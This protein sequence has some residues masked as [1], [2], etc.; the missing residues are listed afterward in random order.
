MVGVD[1][2]VTAARQ[3]SDDG[4]LVLI[5]ADLEG[6]ARWPLGDQ[7]F[8]GV[9][10]TNYL[11]RPL[12]PAIVGAV[13]PAGVLIYE[14]FGTGN[15]RLGRPRNSEFLLRPG[16]LLDAA[17]PVLTIVAYENVVLA[18]P[19]RVV[20]RIAAVGRQHPLAQAMAPPA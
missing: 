18:D 16:E 7:R 9:I 5:E 15:E 17:R 3:I 11:W 10:V 2:D 13:G 14:T 8:A 12:L 6:G 20:Q 19:R 1:R 4:R